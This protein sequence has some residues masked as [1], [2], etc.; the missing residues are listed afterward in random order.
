VDD[1]ANLAVGGIAGALG[2]V[3]LAAANR[4]GFHRD[5]LY[6]I[7]AGHHLAWGYVDQPPLTPLLGHVS[8]AVFGA[9]PRALRV[10][11]ML[12][13]MALVVLSASLCRH[14]GGTSRARI[15]AAVCSAVAA[16]LLAVTHILSTTTFDVLAWV[17]VL[18]LVTRLLQG[19]DP[20][21]WVVVGLVVGIGL[22]N[23]HLVLFLVASLGVGILIGH[24][25]D[26]LR[27]K[28]LL[29]GAAL[30]LLIWSP[31]LIWQATHGWP[32]IDMAR[33]IA[34]EDGTENRAEL[35]PLQLLLLGPLLLPIWGA[36]LLWLWRSD[37][38]KA[39][40]PL[41]FTYPVLL[42]A[43]FIGAGKSYYVAPI[44]LVYLAAGCVVVDRWMT[45]PR[46]VVAVAT[47]VTVSAVTSAIITLPLLPVKDVGGS[48]VAA[49]NDDALETIGWP[50]FTALVADVVETLPPDQRASAILFTSNYGEAG[51][52]DHLGGAFGLPRAYSGHNSYS[53]WG[54]PP[55][56]AGPVVVIGF[57][58]RAYVDTYWNGCTV[59]AHVDDGVGAD[60]EEQ[61]VPIWVCAGPKRPW[62]D[63][64]GD[65]T[66]YG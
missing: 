65:L 53:D 58:Q 19:A 5:E 55:D 21:L 62:A 17:L 64:W 13:G 16:V 57:T 24:R 7:E 56:G 46:R 47:L 60:N 22:L 44:L 28:W 2:L 3:L 48:P 37:A 36:G 1:R 18:W 59:A 42:A 31:N 45:K 12:A 23:K 63:M 41:A 20:R 14:L 30:A 32:Q 34:R 29:V 25:S 51:A 35:I 40:R 43:V 54:I 8:Q 66:S 6:F 9:S 10:P 52:I 38:T 26:V 11:S 49:L 15:L 61:G 27:S 4:Y 50:E 39:L 33:A